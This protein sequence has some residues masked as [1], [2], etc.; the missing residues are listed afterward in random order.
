MNYSHWIEHPG[1]FATI[2]SV[3]IHAEQRNEDVLTD[4]V[5]REVQK[6]S[7]PP[8]PPNAHKVYQKKVIYRDSFLF[9]LAPSLKKL[10]PKSE[11]CKIV[12][13]GWCI[14]RNHF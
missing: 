1:N 8:S 3:E 13:L 12:C 2:T 6:V 7:M 9:I 5:K 11:I 10:V 14:K 4:I